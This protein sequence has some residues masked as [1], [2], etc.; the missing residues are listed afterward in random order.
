MNLRNE[1]NEVSGTTSQDVGRLAISFTKQKRFSSS[2]RSV[3]SLFR[4]P[5]KR[6]Q[7]RI[8]VRETTAAVRFAV[9]RPTSSECFFFFY[10]DRPSFVQSGNKTVIAVMRSNVPSTKGFCL[11]VLERS[12]ED[13]PAT[14][15]DQ[16]A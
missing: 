11:R 6:I 9:Y 7:I 1:K 3:S 13:M 14:L 12:A 2:T 15:M 4:R 5:N 16:N 8:S 10:S